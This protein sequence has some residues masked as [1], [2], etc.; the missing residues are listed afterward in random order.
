[1]RFKSKKISGYTIYAISGVNTI[2]FAIDF[3]NADTRGLLGFAV[4]RHDLKSG[5]R[6]FMKG[7]KVF[8]DIVPNPDEST[9]VSTFDQPVQSFVWD[10]FTAH[11]DNKY[12]YYFYPLKGFP[13]KLDRSSSPIEIAVQSEPLYSNSNSHDIFFNRG[14]ASSQA[15]AR[16][17]DNKSPDEE[18]DPK[19]KAAMFDWLARDLDDAIFKFIAQ[20]DQGDT[21]LSCFY[22]FHYLPVVQAFKKAIDRG[23]HV[24]IIIDAKHNQ[25]NF[26]RDDNL[27]A[28][29]KAGISHTHIIK[30]QSNQ[31]KIQHNKFI[32]FLKGKS[33]TPAAVWTGST[34]I[35]EGGLFGQTNVGHWIRDPQTAKHF[36]DYWDILSQDPGAPPNATAA[37]KTKQNKTFKGSIVSLHPDIPPTELTKIPKGVT[38]IFSPRSSLTMLDTYA[39]LLDSSKV[40]SAITLAFGINDVFKEILTDNT[41]K[42]QITFM[43]LEKKDQ[44]DNSKDKSTFVGVKNNVYEAWG[45]YIKD[46]LYQWTKETNNQLIKLNQH[47]L[48][49]HSKFLLADP[50]GA[51]P[52]VVTG[53]AN[54]SNASTIDNDENMLII[55]ANKRVADIYF[56]EFNR[57]FNHYYFRSVYE[58]Q[59]SHQSSENSLFLSPDDSWLRKYDK[60][61]LRYKRVQAF[62]KMSI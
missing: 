16:R 7:F 54:F 33:Q 42:D 20:A 4:E 56:T 5:E 17:F 35:S 50:L 60:G 38:P 52:I 46:P 62:T 32:V 27:A 51:D 31:N 3:T 45:S 9:T 28:I 39:A 59:K 36:K 8:Q 29:K 13:K 24:Q 55:R 18:T 53:S 2:S 19:K 14:V 40:Y 26:P 57:L 6:Y 48:Y 11:P 61:N 44:P 37:E 34:N 23:V 21:L 10:D 49:I 22:E 41:A 47:V 43:L 1:M 25:E 30:R 58:D 15:F 12:V